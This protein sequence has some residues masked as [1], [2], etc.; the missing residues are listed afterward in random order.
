MATDGGGELQASVGGPLLAGDDGDVFPT[1]FKV[2]LISPLLSSFKESQAGRV[3][4]LF[5]ILD[6]ITAH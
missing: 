1:Q 2:C 5:N 6:I 4:H 3:S